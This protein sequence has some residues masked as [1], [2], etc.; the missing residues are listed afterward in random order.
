MWAARR[1]F[2]CV[3]RTKTF[4]SLY[5][6]VVFSGVRKTVAVGTALAGLSRQCR[7]AACCQTPRL[8]HQKAGQGRFT[9]RPVFRHQ[10]SRSAG[11]RIDK[12]GGKQLAWLRL[13]GCLSALYPI[14]DSVPSDLAC[15][16][17]PRLL[18]GNSLLLL[19][20]PVFAFDQFRF[21]HPDYLKPDYLKYFPIR[22]R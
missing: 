5:P 1:W 2:S 22:I 12:Q 4:F 18:P 9:N 13:P 8:S 10:D 11:C 3:I 20:Q 7:S 16:R 15:V 14:P 6:K 19:L 21:I 17:S